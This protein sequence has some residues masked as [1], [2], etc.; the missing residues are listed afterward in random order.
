M[1][2]AIVDDEKLAQ[3]SLKKILETLCP[4]AEIVA[5]YWAEEL[6]KYE[7]K[8]DF[9]I[10]FLDI[11]LGKMTGLELALQLKRFAPQCNVIFVTAYE[12][13]AIKAVQLHASG[14]VLKPYT[15]EDIQ[16]ELD[17][18]LYPREE[19]PV[20]GKL[21][22]RTFGRFEVLDG[23]MHPIHFSREASRE[24]LAY[25]V[26]AKGTPVR[27]ADIAED[28]FDCE[29]DKNVSKKISQ[30]IRDLMNDLQKAGY[31]D[32]VSK[33]WKNTF[34]N[35]EAVDCDLYRLFDGEP[36]AINRFRNNYLEEYHWACH[37]VF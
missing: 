33:D 22:I 27:S 30:Y 12:Q 32:V 29:M 25:L 8:E 16:A 28:V 3:E 9:D 6:L 23:Q 19:E 14:Y 11:H 31:P 5:F 1:K 24:I 17:N 20:K 36:H 4:G 2:I 35:V 18:L 21:I 13:Y 10:A 15:Q 34:L 7:E 37:S 26:D